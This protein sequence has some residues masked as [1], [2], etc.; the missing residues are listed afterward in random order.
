VEDTEEPA[1]SKPDSRFRNHLIAFLIV[2]LAAIAFLSYLGAPPLLI[3]EVFGLAAILAISAVLIIIIYGGG[4]RS[5][6]KG[7][8]GLR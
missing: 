3:L 2:S 4:I 5:R 6:W 7:L 8:R 1:D